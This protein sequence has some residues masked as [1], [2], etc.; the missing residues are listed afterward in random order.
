M[1]RTPSTSTFNHDRV[2]MSCSSSSTPSKQ[3]IGQI[4]MYTTESPQQLQSW[5]LMAHNTLNDCE[6]SVANSA[7]W[8]WCSAGLFMGTVGNPHTDSGHMVTRNTNVANNSKR[9]MK[10]ELKTYLIYTWHFCSENNNFLKN[11]GHSNFAYFLP[12]AIL[13]RIG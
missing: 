12:S 2:P 7:H 5:V 6:H 13:E 11:F 10:L 9:M 4:M 1:G 8:W 3:I